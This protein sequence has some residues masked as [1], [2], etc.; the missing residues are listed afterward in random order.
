M[1]KAKH[2][3][4]FIEAPFEPDRGGR[5]LNVFNFNAKRYGVDAARVLPPVS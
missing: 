1:T 5:G 2:G 4:H 3:E